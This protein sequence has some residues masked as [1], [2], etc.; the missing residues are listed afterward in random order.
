MLDLSH[1]MT[2]HTFRASGLID[3]VMVRGQKMSVSPS[4]VRLELL[5]ECLPRFAEMRELARNEFGK[6]AE[7]ILAAVDEYEVAIRALAGLCSAQITEDRRDGE[8]MCPVCGT[9]I[10]KFRPLAKIKGFE[11]HW[12]ILC[13]ECDKPFMSARR[14]LCSS[15]GFGTWAI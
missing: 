10:T 12:C 11:D 3:G 15:E 7:L 9:P 8:G 13:A 2:Q 6:Q 4:T 14:K 1:P 5:A